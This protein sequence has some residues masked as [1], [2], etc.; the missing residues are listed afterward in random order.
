MNK[1]DGSMGS[2]EYKLTVCGCGPAGISPLIYMEENQ[3]LDQLIQEGIC[4]MDKSKN[5]GK[6]KIG[7]YQITANSF[8]EVFTEIFT[9]PESPQLKYLVDRKSY[10]DIIS[11]TGMAPKLNFVGD[12]MEDI[13]LY[14]AKKI[15]QVPKSKVF[16]ESSVQ[17]IHIRADGKFEVFYNNIKDN[18]SY[19]FTTEHV[20]LNIGAEQV[21]PPGFSEKWIDK[22]GVIWFSSDFIIGKHDQDLALIL[23]KSIGTIEVTLIGTSHSAFSVLSRLINDFGTLK[24]ADIKVTMLSNR[25]PRLYHQS[26]EEADKAN[27]F[28]DPV[29]DVCPHTGRVNRFSG[30]RCDSFVLA[31][32][33]LDGKYPNVQISLIPELGQDEYDR[34]L[35]GSDISFVCTGYRN[36]QIPIFDENRTLLDLNMDRNGIVTNKNCNPILQSG[37]TLQNLYMYG[38]GAGQQV[39][40][41]NGGEPAYFGRIDGIWFYQHVVASRIVPLILR[42]S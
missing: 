40:E 17:E 42:N 14:F 30:L 5:L 36:K 23:D 31:K 11:Y 1:G 10:Q 18:F 6:G 26:I 9:N 3:L 39:N 28:F 20:L 21:L 22:G 41:A 35:M 12:L 15:N 24:D 27:D 25:T 33:V 32:E 4:L 7:D 8:G 38:L 2:S 19:N 13:G 34:I 16:L 37:R 29:L